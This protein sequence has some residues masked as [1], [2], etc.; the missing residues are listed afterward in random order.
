LIPEL[1]GEQKARLESGGSQL[2][3]LLHGDDLVVAPGAF[4]P[5]TA[6][7]IERLGFDVVYLG[8]NAMGI[9]LGVGQPFVTMT[10]AVDCAR[11]LWRCRP[12]PSD[13]SRV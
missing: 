2:R 9:H 5:F 1:N 6:L 10:E 13:Y 11:G 4:D 8:G 12:H 7:I 3:R